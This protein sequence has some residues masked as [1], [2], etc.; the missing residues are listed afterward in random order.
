MNWISENTHFKKKEQ[1]TS[2]E[3]ATNITIPIIEM[4]TNDIQIYARQESINQGPKNK[5]I[6]TSKT[7]IV[8]T[9]IKKTETYSLQ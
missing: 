6:V 8:K 7:Q 4:Q 3:K 2:T 9:L 1:I 5:I